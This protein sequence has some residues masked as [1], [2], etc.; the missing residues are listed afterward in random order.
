MLLDRTLPDSRNLGD[1]VA[2][3]GSD[4]ITDSS[5]RDRLLF[6]SVSRGTVSI[7]GG[8]KERADQPSAAVWE[9]KYWALSGL[10]NSIYRE[11]SQS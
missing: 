10:E 2:T 11:N 1:S 5:I 9:D 8:I 3:A 6:C 7:S 4:L